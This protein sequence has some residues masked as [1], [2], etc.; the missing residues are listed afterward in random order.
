MRLPQEYYQMTQT[1][2]VHLPH[3]RRAHCRGLA[4]WVY[5][6]VLAQ[7]ACHNAVITA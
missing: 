5:G 4:L 6:T 2:A 7:S 3:L 1:L